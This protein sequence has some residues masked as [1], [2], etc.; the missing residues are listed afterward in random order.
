MNAR[1]TW[2]PDRRTLR[3]AALL[4][5]AKLGLH[6]VLGG[7]YGYNGDELYFIACGRHLAFGYV[8]HAPLVPWI[9]RASSAL[10]GESLPALRFFPAVAGA[11]TI[12]LTI[13]VVRAFG[14]QRFAQTVAGLAMLIAP[15][16]LRMGSILCIPAFEI[17]YWTL[18][19]YFILLA[20]EH[21]RPRL[22]LIAGVLAG[23]GLLNKHTM[24]LWGAGIVGGLALTRRRRQLATRWPW[25]GGA[26]ATVIFLPNLLWQH[27]HGWPTIEFIRDINEDQLDRIPRALFL[28]G[29]GLYMHPL[30][31][32]LVV[33]G[34]SF[35]FSR[36]GEPY[37]LFG[38]MYVLLLAF[39][40]VSHAKPYYLAPAYP[41]VFA[42]GAVRIERWIE[43]SGRHRMRPIVLGGLL[44]GG[45][46]LAP[47]SLPMLPLQTTDRVIQRLFGSA[48]QSPADLTLEFH[49]QFGWPEQAATVAAVY[50]QLPA[51]EQPATAILTHDY[52][53]ASAINFFGSGLGL[54]RAV[55]GHMTYF[56]WG[57]GED[58]AEVVISYGMERASL[59]Q[60]FADV[61]V[62]ATISHPL[63]SAWQRDLPVYVCRSPR[64]SLQDSWPELKRYRFRDVAQAA[65]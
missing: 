27:Q 49:E 1:D 13:L 16:Y 38:W 37:R 23:I 65:R 51:S 60:M 47:F 30:T 9:A 34:V 45:I 20:I 24:L 48:L 28:A 52:A 43:R 41:V 32:P 35:F 54:P 46:A 25:L 15:A 59:E 39:L 61:R 42:A 57:P 58:R 7:R 14:G 50:H 4:F 64:K 29:Q 10:F 6:V 18:C 22:W 62:V 26:I 56:L 40:F 36:M 19:N 21:E 55:S 12:A 63:A 44:L 33:A 31:L 5:A 11:L 3:V 8:D 53:Q 2:M 17:F